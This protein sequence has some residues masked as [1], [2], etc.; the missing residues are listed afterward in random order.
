MKR[1]LIAVL[2]A[3]V[4]SMSFFGCLSIELEGS[5]DFTVTPEPTAVVPELPLDT[6]VLPAELPT[7]V[8]NANAGGILEGLAAYYPWDIVPLPEGSVFVKVQGVE[9][10][11]KYVEYSYVQLAL[12]KSEA[13]EYF[14]PLMQKD[15]DYY[16]RDDDLTFPSLEVQGMYPE[17]VSFT[18]LYAR[19][20]E[21]VGGN[22]A[23]V[24][25]NLYT[26]EDGETLL[27]A[28][29]QV[30]YRVKP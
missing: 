27:I 29:I 23:L 3:A 25:V 8:P 19:Y 6:S 16:T 20:T 21:Q 1:A 14:E 17:V 13:V 11:D 4:L 10:T 24:N 28:E 12:T 26:P 9:D 15:A 7:E 18:S 5:T 30:N 22:V 2:L